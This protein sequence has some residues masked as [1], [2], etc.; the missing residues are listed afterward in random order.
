MRY[1]FYIE[2]MKELLGSQSIDDYILNSDVSSLFD[3]YDEDDVV[4]LKGIETYVLNGSKGVKD[5][6]RKQLYRAFMENPRKYFDS[7]LF[8]DKNINT[9]FSFFEVLKIKKTMRRVRASA[10]DIMARGPK[11]ENELHFLMKYFK[12]Y[13]NLDDKYQREYITKI[14]DKK[15]SELDPE[16]Y[17]FLCVYAGEWMLRESGHADIDMELLAVNFLDS[18]NNVGYANGNVILMSLFDDNIHD[19]LN[20]VKCVCHETQH[21][22]QKNIYDR[23]ASRDS[24]DSQIILDYFENDIMGYEYYQKNYLF[25]KIEY[26]AESIG[27]KYAVK[28][29]SSFGKKLFEAYFNNSYE[30]YKPYEF[31]MQPIC[32][33]YE[34][35]FVEPSRV[36]NFDSFVK[37]NPL[38]IYDYPVLK[39]LYYNGDKLSFDKMLNNDFSLDGNLELFY[40][41]VFCYIQDGKLDGYEAGEV[42]FNN[43]WLVY[44][45]VCER[46]LAM[47]E[48][49]FDTSINDY[50]VSI[51]YSEIEDVFTA[52]VLY[53]FSF[54]TKISNFIYSNIGKLSHDKLPDFE[55]KI[56]SILDKLNNV[57]DGHVFR[58]KMDKSKFLEN[59]FSDLFGIYNDIRK[60]DSIKFI[61][62]RF[63]ELVPPSFWNLNYEGSTVRDYICNDLY[64]NVSYLDNSVLMVEG[65]E[66]KLDDYI[67]LV[68]SRSLGYDIDDVLNLFD[69]MRQPILDDEVRE[70]LFQKYDELLFKFKD[71]SLFLKMLEKVKDSSLKEY[72]NKT[73]LDRLDEMYVDDFE[74]EFNSTVIK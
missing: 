32:T 12:K 17:S 60:D 10:R 63:E 69:L 59:N 34:K 27:I 26:D 25:S 9:I 33:S 52:E 57:L 22:I 42:Q 37:R 47:F 53:Y 44:D 23:R 35:E 71:D 29:L 49:Y 40:D 20:V 72:D 48:N 64:M 73:L 62:S 11:D 8:D 50:G 5:R 74:D 39:K 3:K 70:E 38:L 28:F 54:L 31:R 18:S 66:F 61:T 65:R 6:V 46:V 43:I 15:V 14:L 1:N 58:F 4:L 67:L 30:N 41:Y 16:E 45:K 2:R 19:L 7:S 55:D 51:S 68:V 13:I 56:S 36:S 24:K 21:V